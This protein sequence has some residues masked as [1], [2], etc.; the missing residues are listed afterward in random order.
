MLLLSRLWDRFSLYTTH[1][2]EARLYNLFKAFFAIKFL[3]EP[4]LRLGPSNLSK[5]GLQPMI[6]ALTSHLGVIL[7]LACAIT[8]G[9]RANY[10]FGLLIL[11]TLKLRHV[12]FDLPYTG[13]HYVLELILLGI[14]L[15]YPSNRIRP[16]T[17]Q[18]P[19]MVDG[20][21]CRLVVFAIATVYF[22]AGVQK[23]IQ[24]Y[25]LNGE[26]FTLYLFIAQDSYTGRFFSSSIEL[27][28]GFFDQP[29]P[30]VFQGREWL[31]PRGYTYPNWAIWF[32]VI[33]SWLTIAAE[34]LAPT[35]LLFDRT[36]WIGK[37]LLVPTVVV[38]ALVSGETGFALTNCACVLLLFPRHAPWTYPV[39]FAAILTIHY[40]RLLVLF[41]V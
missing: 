8:I 2:V 29:T 3:L 36:R 31:L 33:Q 6:A 26:F 21:A 34:I 14:L 35:L 12:L 39:G 4:I 38:I 16:E 9:S 18:R 10:R 20:R 30:A 13:N 11:F 40:A 5:L 37:L 15:I 19:A 17:P 28:A 7:L 41:H 24:G 23:L 22:W 25:Y 1:P 32:F 27:L